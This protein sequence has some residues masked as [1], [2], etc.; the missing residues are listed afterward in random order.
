MTT[1]EDVV[2]RLERLE[3]SDD[4]SS[5]SGRVSPSTPSEASSASPSPDASLTSEHAPE[6]T[7]R[8]PS[9]SAFHDYPPDHCSG[10]IAS[11]RVPGLPAKTGTGAPRV[12]HHPK[13][14]APP[15]RSPGLEPLRPPPPELVARMLLHDAERVAHPESVMNRVVYDSQSP[16]PSVSSVCGILRRRQRRRQRRREQPPRLSVPPRRSTAAASRLSPRYRVVS[17]HDATLVFESRMESGNLRRAVQVYPHE[18]DLILSPDVNTRGHTQWFYFSVSN[19]RRGVP[20]KFNVVNLV[21]GD[22]LYI[23]GMR[24]L[25]FSERANAGEGRGWERAG[26]DV[27][28]YQNNIRRR[29]GSCHYTATFTVAFEHDRDTCHVAYCYPYTYTDLQLYLRRLE[30]DPVRSRRF[31]RETMCA[32][33]AGNRCDALTITTP[34]PDEGY[35]GARKRGAVLTARVHP[36]ESNS[37]WMMKG[38]IDFLTGD[39]LDAKMLRDNFVFK[40]VPML[41][42]DGVVNGNYRCSLAGVD[43]NRVWAE[44]NKRAHPTIWH[45]KAMIRKLTEE[46]E[47]VLFCDM[48]GHSR[49]KNVFAYGCQNNRARDELM[50]DENGYNPVA[51]PGKLRDKIYPKI[52]SENYPEAFSFPECSF[53]VQK[54]KESTARVVVWREL[55]VADSL[56]LE[57]SFAGPS[58]GA[59]A[60]AH[61]S[62]AHLEGVGRAACEALLDHRAPDRQRVTR[63]CRELVAAE[64]GVAE[65]AADRSA[66]GTGILRDAP[67][68]GADDADGSDSD[69]DGGEGQTMVAAAAAAASQTRG[70]REKEKMRSSSGVGAGV[71]SDGATGVSRRLR[72]AVSARMTAKRGWERASASESARA[73]VA[74]AARTVVAAANARTGTGT[75]TGGAGTGTG[76]RRASKT[77]RRRHG[78]GM[79]R[80]DAITTESR[81]FAIARRGGVGSRASL[82]VGDGIVHGDHTVDG[83]FGEENFRGNIRRGAAVSLAAVDEV[84]SEEE[85]GGDE[86]DGEDGDERS[87]GDEGGESEL[88]EL[89]GAGGETLETLVL[90]RAAALELL[91]LDAARAVVAR[92]SGRVALLASGPLVVP[93]RAGRGLARAALAPPELLRE[94]GGEPV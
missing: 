50:Y 89:A 68:L 36:G 44:P 55:G 73:V 66:G 69:D 4:A 51:V 45:A 74:T 87:E 63:A 54:S 90:E 62:V 24:P 28:Y 76:T 31:A 57:A 59:H 7:T 2:A 9:A 21:K 20:V 39:S 60:G 22:S 25:V 6:T 34:G 72:S 93:R 5:S 81:S 15:A 42:P 79:R 38:A 52:L 64:L 82:S 85:V 35:D 10:D 77:T 18:Y 19:T 46:R 48:H 83:G 11:T 92:E 65:R 88:E 75:G 91:G 78:D 94:R 58:E 17:P 40:V 53:R 49:K 16:T 86:H 41:N 47:T 33:L 32:T 80:V 27:C 14:V 30:E 37:S 71:G 70:K 56:T 29:D 43:L 1:T 12:P 26:E 8:A 23:D 67:G 84:G 61:F 13:L 3:V